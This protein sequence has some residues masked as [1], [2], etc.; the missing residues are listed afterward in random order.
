MMEE[1][2]VVYFDDLIPRSFFE[3]SGDNQS[4]FTMNDLINDLAKFVSGEFCCRMRDS[5][6]L[7]NI[8]SKTRHFSY[9]VNFVSFVQ[10]LGGVPATAK[11]DIS[12]FEKF[13]ALSEAK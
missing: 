9:A 1:V 4:L 13:E 10:G 5:G 8:S 11:V 12:G 3:H 7:K 6:S 2:G